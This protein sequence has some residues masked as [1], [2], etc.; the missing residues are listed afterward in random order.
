M[1]KSSLARRC[2]FRLSFTFLSVFISICISSAAQQNPPQPVSQDNDPK[3]IMRMASKVNGIA[4]DDVGPWRFKASFTLLNAMGQVID[5]GTFE[6]S[7]VSNKRNKFSFNSSTFSRT[8]YVTSRRWWHS[9]PRDLLPGLLAEVRHGFVM[10][11]IE[12]RFIKGWKLS[13]QSTATGDHSLTCITVD[14]ADATGLQRELLKTTFC[15]DSKTLVLRASIDSFGIQVVHND[16]IQFHGRFVPRDLTVRSPE[17][18]YLQ[19]HLESLESVPSIDSA[20]FSVPKD[21]FSEPDNY[22]ICISE[23]DAKRLQVGTAEPEY[24]PAAL[25][26]HVAGTVDVLT[27]ID[28]DGHVFEVLPIAGP[29]LLQDAALAAVRNYTFKPYS[30]SGGKLLLCTIFEVTFRLPEIN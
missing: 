23:A 16:I 5:R 27:H 7:W 9:G 19:A 11:L 25:S 20:E 2:F 17:R 12:Q 29:L 4:A 28:T 30:N 24:P 21:A 13:K 14:D 18:L 26:A 10:P 15:F 6:E 1:P 3:E 8:T 22:G